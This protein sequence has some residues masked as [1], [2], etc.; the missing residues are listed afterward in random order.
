MMMEETEYRVMRVLEAR[1]DLSQRDLARELGFS[2]G[3]ANYCIRSLIDKDWVKAIPHKKSHER[4]GYQYVLTR[5]GKK[6]QALLT[7][8]FMTSKMREYEGLLA[9]FERLQRGG[10]RRVTQSTAEGDTATDGD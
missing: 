10:R 5:L 7:V 6:Q 1:P 3:K 9:E 8:R 2:L 4:G